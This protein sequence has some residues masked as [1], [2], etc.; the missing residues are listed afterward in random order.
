VIDERREFRI[1]ARMPYQAA[2]PD[3]FGEEL[4]GLEF[5]PAAPDLAE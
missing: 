1:E 5:L 2:D 4:T 3:G